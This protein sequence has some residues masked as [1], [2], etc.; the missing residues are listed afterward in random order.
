MH[1]GKRLG[2]LDTD[3]EGIGDREW[4]ASSGVSLTVAPSHSA[5]AMNSRPVLV[6]PIS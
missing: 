1:T 2:N 3:V 5:M 6:S 4:A